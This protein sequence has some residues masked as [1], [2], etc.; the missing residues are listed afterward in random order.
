MLLAGSTGR[1]LLVV[2]VGGVA[3]CRNDWFWCWEGGGGGGVGVGAAIEGGEG[4]QCDL[5]LS[6]VYEGGLCQ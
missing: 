1:V 4:Q 3:A 6:T 5:F 2:R